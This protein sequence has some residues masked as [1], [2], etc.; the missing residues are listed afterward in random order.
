[1]MVSGIFEDINKGESINITT[2]LS[3]KTPPPLKTASSNNLS[4]KRTP[5]TTD[6][7][8]DSSP[9][10]VFSPP[11]S[12]S[13]PMPFHPPNFSYSASNNVLKRNF[14]VSFGIISIG[15]LNNAI[16]NPQEEDDDE[17]KDSGRGKEGQRRYFRKKGINRSYSFAERIPSTSDTISSNCKRS[18]RASKTD[19]WME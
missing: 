11:S 6:H 14:C 12:S 17:E 4:N 13:L 1:M 7:T 10:F 8:I 2:N 15:C 19:P 18:I 3:N 16:N 9:F 5:H